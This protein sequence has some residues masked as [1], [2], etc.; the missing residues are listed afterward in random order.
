MAK[1]GVLKIDKPKD[2][3]YVLRGLWR[4]LSAHAGALALAVVLTMVTNGLALLG[5]ALSGEAI[6]RVEQGGDFMPA[7]LAIAGKMAVCFVISCV[8]ARVLAHLMIR[9]S[10]Q[11]VRRMRDD[12]FAKL[13]RLPTGYYDGHQTGDIMSRMSY[14]IDTINTSLTNDLIQVGGGVV[15]AVG[16]F[17][18]MLRLSPLLLAVVVV[19]IP[20]GLWWVGRIV[21]RLRPLSRA[22][23]RAMGELGGFTEEM[24]TGLRTLRAYAREEQVIGRFDPVNQG[25]ARGYTDV[26]CMACR[27]GAT[28]NFTGNLSL[29]MLTVAGALLHLA[30]RLALG[31]LSSFVLYAKKVS[32]LIGEL[33]NLAG[34]L[35]SAMAAAERVFQMLDQP[36]EEPDAPGAADLVHPEGA[37]RLDGVSFGYLP[38]QTVLHDLSLAVAPGRLAAIVGETG[39]GKTS[40]INL[41][42][43]YY[44]A[45]S[46]LITVDGQDIRA[47]RRD[48][49]RRS[50]ALVLQDTWLFE[51]TIYDNLRYGNP[52]ASREQVVEAA[53][54]ARIHHYIERLP[55][56][57]DTPLL[58]GGA[59]L[60]KGQRQLMAIAR[61]MLIDA[62]MLIL[63]EATSNVDTR[64]EKEIQAAMRRLMQDKT[65]FVI[66]H[67]LS[68]IIDADVILLLQDGDVIEQGTHRELMDKKGAYY[69]LFH[70]QFE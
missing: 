12:L 1:G 17:G 27:V 35:Q 7:V 15:T 69:R 48:S 33:A 47:V 26:E 50:Y 31:D 16:A 4:Y 45:D 68:T 53:K 38:G 2:S 67:R 43:R 32:G 18:M 44:D 25:A 8:A 58:E 34:D 57:Y 41:L 62:P 19:I 40:I 3:R 13:H 64:T 10:Q 55:A 51:G 54:A 66:A 21:R 29:S 37:V 49:L 56:G 63:D 11:V 23:S 20:F 70:A 61:A 14:D 59:N 5:P 9:I 30:G 52:S 24:V 36:E 60:S 22:R 46:G 39:A 28:V 42:M 65:C 6:N